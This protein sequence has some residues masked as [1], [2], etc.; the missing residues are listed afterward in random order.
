[1][2][3]FRLKAEELMDNLL[4]YFEG[5]IGNDAEI[6]FDGEALKIEF[7]DGR[8]WLLHIHYHLTQIWLSSPV[9]GAHHYQMDE[10]G[11]WVNTRVS[12]KTSLQELLNSELLPKNA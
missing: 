1:M 5:Q 2:S 10:N 11:A 8:T 3:E 12:D 4:D 9:S 6:D 7:E